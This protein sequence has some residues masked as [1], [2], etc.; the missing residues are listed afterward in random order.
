[1]NEKDFEILQDDLLEFV[2]L[3]SDRG[4]YQFYLNNNKSFTIQELPL[5]KANEISFYI[6]DRLICKK[7]NLD[8]NYH[9]IEIKSLLEN[10]KQIEKKL[11][12]LEL[13]RFLFSKLI[14]KNSVEKK[15]S[16]FLPLVLRTLHEGVERYVKTKSKCE[17]L[18]EV[19]EWAKKFFTNFE[20]WILG[21]LS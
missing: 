9:L 12:L 3:I 15:L 10:T 19:S 2:I 13:I 7:E 21:F 6:I 11:I 5:R 1:M 8:V 18:D 4:I 16:D 20:K 17:N 14:N